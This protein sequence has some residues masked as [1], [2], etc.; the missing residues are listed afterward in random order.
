[1]IKKSLLSDLVEKFEKCENANNDFKVQFVMFALG[2]LLCPTSSLLVS[3][4][5]LTSLR[6]PGE[7]KGKNWDGH[8]F[9]F[10]RKSVRSFEKE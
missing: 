8:A 4:K 5:Y 9:N 2:T 7:I 1:M 6:I 10:L 3:W